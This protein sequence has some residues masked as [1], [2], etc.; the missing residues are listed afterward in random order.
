[1]LTIASFVNNIWW[2]IVLYIKHHLATQELKRGVLCCTKRHFN[3][4]SSRP[5]RYIK[6][7]FLLVYYFRMADPNES[8]HTDLKTRSFLIQPSQHR[9]RLQRHRQLCLPQRRLLLRPLAQVLQCLPWHR[10]DLPVVHLRRHRQSH[11]KHL[12]GPS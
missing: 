12:S 5:L 10:L 9:H 3:A 4:V 11:P 2:Y 1:M 6:K 7:P 8:M